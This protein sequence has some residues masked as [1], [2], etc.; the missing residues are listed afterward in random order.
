MNSKQVTN[1]NNAKQTYFNVN[2]IAANTDTK[3]W[4]GDCGGSLV[5]MS[6]GELTV[7]LMPGHYTVEFG[8]GTANYPLH[9]ERDITTT[10]KI[11]ESFPS[12]RRPIFKF[13]NPDSY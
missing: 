12:C 13:D 5:N 4:L 7:G 6:I 1:V 9:V 10:Q 3:I 8:L 11:L 2:I